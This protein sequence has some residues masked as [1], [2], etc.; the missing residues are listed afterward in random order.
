MSDDLKPKY[1]F[2]DDMPLI[3][4]HVYKMALEHFRE[5]NKDVGGMLNSVMY[6]NVK[7][8]PKLE[9]TMEKFVENEKILFP[10]TSL[11]GNFL[12]GVR[13]QPCNYIEEGKV[14]LVNT[15]RLRDIFDQNPIQNEVFIEDPAQPDKL[16]NSID[17]TWRIRHEF[18]MPRIP[19]SMILGAACMIC[20]ETEE[21]KQQRRARDRVWRRF[22]VSKLRKLKN[23]LTRARAFQAKNG[24]WPDQLMPHGPIK[25]SYPKGGWKARGRRRATKEAM[26]RRWSEMLK[27]EAKAAELEAFSRDFNSRISM[28]EQVTPI[29]ESEDK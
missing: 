18:Q 20:D 28:A 1:G 9:S 23:N 6:A 27:N 10:D 29:P 24:Y 19:H 2:Q 22:Q 14:L 15:D 13:I 12:S 3:P 8:F 16:F 26:N 11:F 25:L 17:M 5:T 21:E 7:D 4:D